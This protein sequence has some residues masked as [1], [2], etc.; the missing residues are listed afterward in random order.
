[1]STQAGKD[2]QGKEQQTVVQQSEAR[3]R[4]LHQHSADAMVLITEEGIIT[5]AS[6][7]L[8]AVLGYTPAEC[9]GTTIFSYIHPDDIEYVAGKLAS[10]L[11]APN[12]R[13]SAE[14]R[15]RHKNGSWVWLEAT[16]SNYLHDPLIHAIIGNF[17][18]VT[19]RKQLE[20]ARQKEK[21]FQRL[22]NAASAA[23]VSSLDHLTGNCSYDR[24][25][26]RGLL[27]HRLA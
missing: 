12:A 23:L 2:I 21:E 16:G 14:Y 19:E 10:V 15:A 3:F 22:L 26:L 4:V 24:A 25:C 18:N 27:P 5:D 7:S 1:M 8:Q 20:I 11:L 6:E 9:L 13:V 17:R